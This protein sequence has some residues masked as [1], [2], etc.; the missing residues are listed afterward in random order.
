MERRLKVLFEGWRFSHH[1]YGIVFSMQLIYLHKNYG[2]GGVKGHLIDIYVK[3]ADHLFAIQNS[4]AIHCPEFY[5]I[6]NSFTE[7]SGQEIDLIFRQSYRYNITNSLSVPIVVFYTNEV[8][9]FT[10]HNKFIVEKIPFENKELL[11]QYLSENRNITLLTPSLFSSWG[12][13]TNIEEERNMIIP[14]GVE[15]S[16]YHKIHDYSIRHEFRLKYNIREDDYVMLNVGA[17]TQNKGVEY[18]LL[19]L[20]ILINVLGKTNIKMIFKITSCLYG[21]PIESFATSLINIG[22]FS[23]D[24]YEN[25]KRYII[26]IDDV[27]TSPE[28]NKMYNSCDLYFSPY[29]AE[30]FGMTMLEALAS[31]MNIVIPMTGATK[32]YMKDIY[33]NGGNSFITYISS[34]IASNDIN[35][36]NFFRSDDILNAVLQSI[37][38]NRMKTEEEYATLSA[39]I[40]DNYS[41]SKVSEHLYSLFTKLTS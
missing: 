29:L 40:R 7:Y 28:I 38:K 8:D 23:R 16:I 17:G 37:D 13:K 1:S 30:G 36:Y 18:I 41:W 11:K 4:T 21:N 39:Y 20:H 3:E 14:H 12:M 32:E 33:D 5:D 27:L 2:P 35:I 24:N 25:M 9:L 34:E 19:I 10:D 22:Y 6:L 26:F 15:T 31:G